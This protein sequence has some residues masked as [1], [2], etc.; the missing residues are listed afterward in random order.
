MLLFLV[1]TFVLQERR[2]QIT[3]VYRDFSESKGYKLFIEV[4]I[5][6]FDDIKGRP[7]AEFF[8][9]KRI[10]MTEDCVECILVNQSQLLQIALFGK[11]IT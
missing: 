9:G 5:H 3:L 4:R 1:R 2:R 11:D 7:T 8:N 10:D 6:E